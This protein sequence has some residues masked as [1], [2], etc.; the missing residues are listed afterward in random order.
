[1]AVG[2]LRK[3]GS[4]GFKKCLLVAFC[5]MIGPYQFAIKLENQQ[6]TTMGSQRDQTQ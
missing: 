2:A 6:I 4:R 1:M 5:P 3:D